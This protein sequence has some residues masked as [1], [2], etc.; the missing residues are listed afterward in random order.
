M[1]YI[2]ALSRDAVSPAIGA[3]LDA[4]QAKLGVLPNMLRTLAHTP[5]ALNTYMQLSGA[6][7]SGTFNPKQREQIALA[8]GEA[9]DCGYCLAAH[10]AIGKMVGL[11]DGQIAQARNGQAE[12]P[13]DAAVLT[14][15][16]RIVETRGHVPTAE[17]DAFKAAGFDDAAILEVLSNVVLNI[18]T[19]Y[20]NHIAGTEIDFPVM[21]RSIAA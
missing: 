1:S 20:T 5:V 9:N 8:V 7:A 19:N 3:T 11:T 15:A 13:R 12:S 14:L 6:T 16:Q 21:P 4:V 10:G 2:P 18:F 17:L